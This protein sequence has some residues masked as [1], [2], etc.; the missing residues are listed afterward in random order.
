V[1]FSTWGVQRRE[2]RRQGDYRLVML[3]YF[4]YTPTGGERERERE[5]ERETAEG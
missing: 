3:F 1:F 5:R 4:G 2:E